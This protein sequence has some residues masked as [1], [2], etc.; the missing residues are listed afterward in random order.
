VSE[1]NP[2]SAVR[3]VK[4]L[5]L[6]HWLLAILAVLLLAGAVR[7][8]SGAFFDVGYAPEQYIAFS[9]AK[10]A[11]L[12]KIDCGYCHFQAEKGAHAGV[13]PMSVCIGCHQH[14]E[15]STP[16]GQAE[17]KRLLA[18]HDNGSYVDERTG[19]RKDGG[20]IHWERVHKLPDHVYFTHEWHVKAGVACQT[21]HGPVETMERVRQVEDLSMGWCLSCHRQTDYV[22]AGKAASSHQVG[23]HDYSVDRDILQVADPPAP[24]PPRRIKGNDEAVAAFAR[25]ATA[26]ALS[27]LPASHRPYYQ[28]AA[29]LMN[30]PTSCNICH[31]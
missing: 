29:D 28:T 27:A 12:L 26:A 4:G 2:A 3:V 5:L 7:W 23:Y 15:V 31:Q 20:V 16:E 24:T 11:G 8:L 13:P 18:V 10:H 19:V 9:H 22:G 1:L 21:C 14:V 30:A 25:G 17:V 6:N